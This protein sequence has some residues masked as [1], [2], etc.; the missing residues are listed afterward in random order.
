[1]NKLQIIILWINLWTYTI[2]FKV[3]INILLHKFTYK[4]IVNSSPRVYEFVHEDIILFELG[5]FNNWA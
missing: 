5:S 3:Y 2:K 4:Y 1:M